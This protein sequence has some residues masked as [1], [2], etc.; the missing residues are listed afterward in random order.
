MSVSQEAVVEL[1]KALGQLIPALLESLSSLHHQQ[2]AQLLLSATETLET[3]KPLVSSTEYKHAFGLRDAS[4]DNLENREASTRIR[5]LCLEWSNN[6]LRRFVLDASTY[7]DDE[8]GQ[9]E[10]PASALKVIYDRFD[11]VL[12]MSQQ[13]LI[14][15]TLPLTLVEEIMEANTIPSCSHIFDYVES[16]VKQLTADL[17]PTRGKGL[18]L[19]RMCNELLRR[20]SKPSQ[21]HT[22]FAGRVLSLLA[23]VFPLGERSGVNLRGDFNV[24]NNTIIE[25][26][27]GSETSEE[28]DT[29][30][31]ASANDGEADE[32]KDSVFKVHYD[33]Y[34]LFWS[35]QKF[36][37]NPALLM[38]ASGASRPETREVTP[39]ATPKQDGSDAHD[40]DPAPEGASGPMAVL[41]I[42][43]HKIV[44]LFAAVTK[45]ERELAGAANAEK[46]GNSTNAASSKRNPASD[47]STGSTGFFA[48]RS[49]LA[50]TA[51]DDGE[52]AAKR[53]KPDIVDG[54]R[55]DTAQN[56]TMDLEGAA[57]EVEADAADSTSSVTGHF[58][59]K[60]L[61]GRKLFE[62]EI[63]DTSFRKHILVQYLVLFQYLLSF[64]P[65]AKE[66]WKEWK[67]KTLQAAFTL[68]EADERW[69]RTTWRDIQGL[70]RE[71]QPD[72]RQFL[73]AVLEILKRET[74]WIRWKTESCPSIE[75]PPLSPEQ[76]AS[77]ANARS[78]LR[79]KPP[80]FPHALGTAALSELWLDG[81]A[82]PVPGTR[83]TEDEM[84]NEITVTTDGLE[85]LEFP[86]P[87]PSLEHYHK[88][89]KRE[90]MK[91]DM[92]KKQLGID[93][94]IATVKLTKEDQEKLQNDERIQ[95]TLEAMQSLAW[96]A[97]RIASRDN[98]HLF[99]KLDRTEDIEGLLRVMEEERNPKPKSE[100]A[101]TA[102]EVTQD[103]NGL[104]EAAVREESKEDGDA[105]IDR[106]KKSDSVEEASKAEEG[107]S[108]SA[109]DA[110]DAEEENNAVAAS[111]VTGT[112][113]S[114]EPAENAAVP[115]A[116]PA[117]PVSPLA[118][119][120]Q[121]GEGAQ[122]E[123]ASN[124]KTRQNKQE[125]VEDGQDVEMADA[126]A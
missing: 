35:T 106:K 120:E 121:A 31:Q 113:D 114:K 98:L 43:T 59:P 97:L 82:P 39:A 28:Q 93:H 100:P 99:K 78:L 89:I 118:E 102:A 84:G 117:V 4:S 123:Q 25:D 8:D 13:D 85:E 49:I 26:R 14:D 125:T 71:I 101:K 38:S 81:L 12:S 30:A 94:E 18:V 119:D 96:R 47:N 92:R 7:L 60:F 41:R 46:N 122:P 15:P 32:D 70:L 72:G 67:N 83:R 54:C 9:S 63:R 107:G 44:K 111:E 91:M 21:K 50:T 29:T 87:I 22:V 2:P 3:L 52:R 6:E 66:N 73:E 1:R 86:P 36:F 64:T 56:D 19:L 61:T 53:F 10:L 74:N 23:A 69:I 112:Q 24:E 37:S 33:F 5:N 42:N 90:Q 124:E 108:E 65:T 126:V 51:T 20:L 57:A 48:G 103:A 104:S 62:Y 109:A 34:E 11:V 105:D 88:S 45:R 40:E 75:K 68:E 58:F 95:L 110:G 79:R 76:I 80:P 16:R 115:V 17:H 116:V 27:T 77:F 55:A